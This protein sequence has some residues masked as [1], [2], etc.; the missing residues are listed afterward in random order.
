MTHGLALYFFMYLFMI[1]IWEAVGSNE[2]YP[3]P[4]HTHT[5]KKIKALSYFGHAPT[6]N[7]ATLLLHKSPVMLS[8]LET[9]TSCHIK[10]NKIKENFSTLFLWKMLEA[11]YIL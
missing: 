1:K 5:F 7:T 11:E 2:N 3:P 9:S 8:S 10:S 6:T 4:T